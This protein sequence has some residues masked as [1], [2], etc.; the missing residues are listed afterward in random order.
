MYELPECKI[1]GRELKI[2]NNNHLAKH[3]ITLAEYVEKYGNPNVTST[4]TRSPSNAKKIKEKLD[5]PKKTMTRHQERTIE[6]IMELE[7]TIRVSR[8]YKRVMADNRYLLND[9]IEFTREYKWVSLD[10]ETTGLDF[11]NDR[12]AGICITVYTPSYED[13]YYIPIYHTDLENNLLPG[14]IT[15]EEAREFLATLL[16]VDGVQVSCHTGIFDFLFI[17][18]FGIK[19]DAWSLRKIYK[20]DVYQ[21]MHVLN[22]N[23]PSFKLKD[24]YSKYAKESAD[25]YEDLFGSVKFN[26]VPLKVAT[27]YGAGD[28]YKTRWMHE[29][30]K[31]NLD[32]IGNL[33]N[34]FYNIEMPLIPVLFDMRKHGI[35]VDRQRAKELEDDF[36]VK[37]EAHL[38]SIYSVV[39]DI[40]LR[41]PKQLSN[42]LFNELGYPDLSK[43]STKASVMEQLADMGYPVAEDILA[44]KGYDKILSTYLEPVDTFINQKTGK[45]HCRFN[46]CGARTG[47]FSSSDPNLQ[48]I[49]ARKEEFRQVRTM[50]IADRGEVLMSSDFSQIEPRL[51][52]HVS[53]DPGLLDIYHN[54]RDIYTTMAARIFKKPESE[55]LDGSEYR[56]RMKT[57][58]LAFMYGMS[59]RGLASRLKVS[60]WEA[61]AILNGLF[62]EFSGIKQIIDRFHKFCKLNGYVETPFGR[63]RRIP[64]IWSDE[65]WI[66]NKASRTILNSVIQGGAADI[67]KLAM[68]NVGYDER[69]KA[70]GGRMLLTVHDELIVSAPVKTAIK[71]AQYLVEDMTSAVKLDVPLKCDCEVFVDGRWEGQSV[72]LNRALDMSEQDFID[73]CVEAGVVGD[74]SLF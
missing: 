26:Y 40:N 36:K 53:K 42:A 8:K 41:S 34:V 68:L 33:K 20:W 12:V 4:P 9:I 35:G 69:I 43:G 21:G 17:D 70:L 16:S 6:D 59:D 39:G 61:A 5:K 71:V 51:L 3:A 60:R 52:A 27:Q 2:I 73:L 47:R 65:W 38:T 64:D 31:Q 25:R 67:M 50:F 15:D 74:V 24:I 66:R 1:C 56:K 29:F 45:V 13:N 63:K 22:E 11:L 55:C 32:T 19:F 23:E 30:Q 10:L 14:Q 58:F 46:P 49:P 37:R 57:L 18:S 48:N 62:E 28:P 7:R 72:S 44:Y 54:N